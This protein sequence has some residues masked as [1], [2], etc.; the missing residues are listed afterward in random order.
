MKKDSNR[1]QLIHDA[2]SPVIG[3]S[4]TKQDKRDIAI[5]RARL[6][7]DNFYA[8][9]GVTKEAH[10]QLKRSPLR[11]QLTHNATN[12][13][14]GPYPS[15]K[16]KALNR[17]NAV[18]NARKLADDFYAR[19]G[20]STEQRA[21]VKRNAQ[22]LSEAT[23]KVRGQDLTPQT[24]FERKFGSGRV[25]EELAT[26]LAKQE[27]AEYE[28]RVRNLNSRD[29]DPEWKSPTEL[30][31]DRENLRRYMTGEDSVQESIEQAYREGNFAARPVYHSA[32]ALGFS[33]EDL[34]GKT[35]GQMAEMA[36]DRMVDLLQLSGKI[37]DPL[38]GLKETLPGGKWANDLAT[39]LGAQ[40]ITSPGD[41]AMDILAFADPSSSIQDRAGAAVNLP[42]KVLS[43]DV[44]G[45]LL[46]GGGKALRYVINAGDI[47]LA[48][49]ATG[50]GRKEV[51]NAIDDL[52]R[53]QRQSHR[54][55]PDLPVHAPFT[56]SKNQK[57]EIA[58]SPVRKITDELIAGYK[59]HLPPKVKSTYREQ[60]EAGRQLEAFGPTKRSTNDL[61]V[62]GAY[63]S[64][65]AGK[66]STI[67]PGSPF[68]SWDDAVPVI[69]TY[70]GGKVEVLFDS[71]K[72]PLVKK[73]FAELIGLYVPTTRH[74]L[75]A[76]Q[77]VR[78]G[79]VEKTFIVYMKKGRIID[80]EVYSMRIPRRTVHIE[81]GYVNERS[82][83]LG[84]DEVWIGHN[85]PG[86]KARASE[87]DILSSIMNAEGIENYKG[88]IITNHNEVA[89]IKSDGS[90]HMY[91]I[92]NENLRKGF[93]LW[94]GWLK[95]INP[96][97]ATFEVMPEVARVIASVKKIKDKI[98]VVA[99]TS[100]NEIGT[101][102]TLKEG[103][104]STDAEALMAGAISGR[105]RHSG[106]S[107]VFIYLPVDNPARLSRIEMERLARLYNDNIIDTVY[108]ANGID[109]IEYIMYNTNIKVEVKPKYLYGRLQKK[110]E[111]RALRRGGR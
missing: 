77:I 29:F 60:I 62:S 98:V 43:I 64:S 70:L 105:A 30:E 69:K 79:A 42:L 80:T 63:D 54:S 82:K 65:D 99:T 67:F 111:S 20:L 18:A 15:E 72:E 71:V 47:E 27:R 41:V 101:M 31:I 59:S 85:H 16:Q 1:Q 75:E 14:T 76:V 4:V 46:K 12:G 86:G 109:V 107:K 89:H 40:L 51:A 81:A 55:L 35:V 94:P 91:K 17:K 104:L 49:R 103:V 52:W 50:L 33:D 100:E 22:R 24:S 78:D 7:L 8:Q 58:N 11:Q 96:D 2:T 88:D 90:V 84:A 21:D 5:A 53:A 45:P 102:F 56:K 95:A 108:S 66:K 110:L 87:K 61:S 3:S 25:G 34:R 97:Q 73:G 9:A 37:Q 74:V 93:A 44:G 26:K 23:A 83:A 48:R 36:S 19:A 6:A 106:S 38:L 92:K 10:E 32:Q 13:Y 39:H 28:Y 57:N 68:R